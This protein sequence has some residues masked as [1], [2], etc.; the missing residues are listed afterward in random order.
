MLR[1]DLRQDMLHLP[2]LKALPVSSSEIVLAEVVSAALPL[3]VAQL[4]LLV[5]AYVGFAFTVSA[6]LSSELRLMLLIVSPFA[7]AALD[8]AMLTIQNA[9]AVLFPAFVR[10]GPSI[11]AGVEALGQ[12]VLSFGGAIVCLAIGLIVPLVAGGLL[13]ATLRL[14]AGLPTALGA[15]VVVASIVLAA[16]TYAV[17]LG[18]GR[19][20]DRAE[21]SAVQ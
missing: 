17:V 4:A 6:P 18:L 20:F 19:A 15:G 2:F 8:A 10:L 7:L 14:R 11:T 16:E 12:N 21:P 5:V 9:T 13:A 3:V 1:N